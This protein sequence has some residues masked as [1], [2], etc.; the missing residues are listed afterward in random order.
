[1][2]DGYILRSG[3]AS[4]VFFSLQRLGRQQINPFGCAAKVAGC[5][6]GCVWVRA[7]LRCRRTTT[8]TTMKEDARMDGR[9]DRQTDGE[10]EE[11]GDRDA[12]EKGRQ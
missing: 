3:P 8:T 7:H 2:M 1:M 12:S 4:D 10:R 11:R 9:R 6:C 5:V